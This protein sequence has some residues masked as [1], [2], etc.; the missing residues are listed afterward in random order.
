ALTEDEPLALQ[1]ETPLLYGAGVASDDLAVSSSASHPKEL[2]SDP[3]LSRL[4][5]G[6][7]SAIAETY[8]QHSTT[9]RAFALRLLGDAAAAE[10]LVHDVF[11]ALPR[12]V[13]T[14]E[15]RSSLKTF[16]LSIAVN[17]ARRH[18]RVARRRRAAFQRLVLE[19]MPL[20]RDPEHDA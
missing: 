20:S 13:R 5:A 15:G 19:P 7:A 17:H 2:R 12:A 16:L 14:F 8:A 6:D 4:R 18:V 3:F 10:D 1:A 11:V 9:I